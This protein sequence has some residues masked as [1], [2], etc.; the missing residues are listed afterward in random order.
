LTQLK[1][2]TDAQIRAVALDMPKRITATETKFTQ[3]LQKL[4]YRIRKIPAL[5]GIAFGATRSASSIWSD[6]H[7]VMQGELYN[8][9]G[10]T[11]WAAKN[12]D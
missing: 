12:S 8:T 7:G 11:S 6:D 4:D 5:V 1:N 3:Q 2:Q 10:G 9:G